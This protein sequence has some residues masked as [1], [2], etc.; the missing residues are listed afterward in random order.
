MDILETVDRP[1]EL[2]SVA[3]SC[4]PS[5][6]GIPDN[7]ESVFKAVRENDLTAIQRY[8][9]EGG[10]GIDI[11]HG[12]ETGDSVYVLKD[13]SRMVRQLRL[14]QYSLLHVA[15]IHSTLETIQFLVSHGASVHVTDLNQMTPLFVAAAVQRP[16]VMHFLISQGAGV[17]TQSLS[18]KTPLIQAIENK[19][20]RC[21]Q[22]LIDA[23]ADLDLADNKGTTP[24]FACL[25]VGK[26]MDL[27]ILR[28]LVAGGCAVDLPN[29]QGATPMMV[30][31]GFGRTDAV[32]VLLDAGA[33]INLVDKA[34]K[35]VFH[36][37]AGVNTALYLINNGAACDC[38]DKHGVR[39]IDRAAQV[40][41][42]GML[43]LLLGCD[44]QRTPAIMD[45]PRVVQSRQ[46]LP[47]F[48]KW[49][50]QE[51]YNPRELKRLCRQT[52]R[53]CL[54]HNNTSNMEA[55]PLPRLLKDFLLAKHLDLT[56]ESVPVEHVMSTV[57]V[58]LENIRHFVPG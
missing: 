18:G 34:G 29:K 28:A 32:Q 39:P 31:V 14:R 12:D 54:G 45:V 52:I 49:L 58:F 42:I 47:I 21:V 56:F 1:D 46:S 10:V 35:N 23:G 25:A 53:H 27:G 2:T 3:V 33:N 11:R 13:L 48:D 44:C 6:V 50:Q 37:A 22:L 41:H 24:L 9:H 4:D 19:S 30:A 16:D 40:G 20:L 7:E 8:L 38:P 55:L 17:N 36:M 5:C 51:L 43:R 57:P 15:V 26:G